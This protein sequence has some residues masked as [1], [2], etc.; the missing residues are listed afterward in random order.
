MFLFL[1]RIPIINSPAKKAGKG[2]TESFVG[3]LSLVSLYLR[4]L[5]EITGVCF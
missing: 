1:Q 4:V 5:L 2:K 3:L